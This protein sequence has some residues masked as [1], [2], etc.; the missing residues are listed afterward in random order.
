M[1]QKLIYISPGVPSRGEERKQF[2]RDA[3]IP[4]SR[5]RT[6]D[7]YD[8]LKMSL[9]STLSC[10]F[11]LTKPRWFV[12]TTSSAFEVFV[13]FELET[14][15]QARDSRML[16]KAVCES[17][18]GWPVKSHVYHHATIPKPP[19]EPSSRFH[20]DAK[21]SPRPVTSLSVRLTQSHSSWHYQPE[22]QMQDGSASCMDQAKRD[23]VVISTQKAD[24]ARRLSISGTEMH[25]R[26]AL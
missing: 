4:K 23:T 15:N 5:L 10:A 11:N 19:L 22:A 20:L 1:S 25:V 7:K 6:L 2:I 12:G 18:R 9:L 21:L 17:S 24:R 16:Y 3:V 14:F 8:P 26:S 13:T